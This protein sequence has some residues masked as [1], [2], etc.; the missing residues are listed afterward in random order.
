MIDCG[1]ELLAIEIKYS[2][3]YQSSYI[4]SLSAFSKISKKP[5]RSVLIYRG[6]TK[7]LRDDVVV[8]PYQQFLDELVAGRII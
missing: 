5:V 6:D 4:E 7:Q 1:K 8:W 2:E 3:K